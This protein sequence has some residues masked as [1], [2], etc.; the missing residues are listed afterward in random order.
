MLVHTP[1]NPVNPN[2]LSPISVDRQQVLHAVVKSCGPSTGPPTHD[3]GPV[4]KFDTFSDH[5]GTIDPGFISVI[6]QFKSSHL[7]V[8]FQV[9][10]SA[11][12]DPSVVVNG[13]E[14]LHIQ[15]FQHSVNYPCI[16]P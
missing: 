10:H 4:L 14:A 6:V 16:P 2:D 13:D 15:S 5:P 1:I 7:A 3:D 11:I 12:F 8:T 9:S